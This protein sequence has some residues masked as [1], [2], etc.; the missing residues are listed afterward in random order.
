M[1]DEIVLYD[2]EASPCARRVKVFL[3][4]KGIEFTTQTIDLSKME[5]K[6]PEYLRINP[7]GLVPAINHNGRI[8]FES[9]VINDYLEDNFPKVSLIPKTAEGAIEAKKWESYELAMANTYRP[10][11]YSK[12]LGPLH[13]LACT[14]DEFIF[15]SA[16]AT[17]NPG[18]LAWQEKVW[19]LN[20][21]SLSEQQQYQKK[22]GQFVD[23]VERRLENRKYLVD[24]SFSSADISV[25]PRL[26][27]LPLVGVKLDSY[28]Y[29]N[30]SAWINRISQRRSMKSTYTKTEKSMAMLNDSGLTTL[31]NR[32]VY[33]NQPYS[34]ADKI[35][36]SILRPIL[37][38][39]LGINESLLARRTTNMRISVPDAEKEA[40]VKRSARTLSVPES[41]T[42]EPLMFYG[43]AGSP[44]SDRIVEVC[45]L[46]G[47]EYTYIAIDMAS[48]EHM[49]KPF[50]F[51]NPAE[52]L[53]I[54]LHGDTVIHDSLFMAEYLS[55]KKSSALF[56]EDSFEQ[57]QIRMWNS[58]DMGMRK[59][60]RPLF[61][62]LIEKTAVGESDKQRCIDL[63]SEKMAYLEGELEGKNYLVGDRFTYADIALYT[64]L[65][66]FESL[67]I[68]SSLDGKEAINHWFKNIGDLLAI[69]DKGRSQEKKRKSKEKVKPTLGVAKNAKERSEINAVNSNV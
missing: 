9:S 2:Y 22:L 19:N 32:I 66:T 52:E 49:E 4:E 69:S 48:K 63:L 59:E 12:T 60:Y 62:A 58:F 29:P 56:S 36:V 64:R 39:K 23:L 30:V 1:K 50:Q 57:A 13:H 17:D 37:R 38:K 33:K 40:L 25:Y 41:L 53:P 10:L 67:G 26:T 55:S 24:D 18:H 5:Q 15:I 3:I 45:K 27:M 44:V 6:S 28:A 11:M 31:I 34:I 65:A 47:I 68:D 42:N 8:I 43:C 51:L 46:L 20:V 54:L 14:L 35:V 61:F 16:Q 7:N 21:L